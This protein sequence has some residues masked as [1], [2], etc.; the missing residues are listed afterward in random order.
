MSGEW[1]NLERAIIAPVN[2]AATVLICEKKY[3]EFARTI[4]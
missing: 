2:A 1:C 3:L 4:P